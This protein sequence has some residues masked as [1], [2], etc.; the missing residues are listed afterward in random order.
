MKNIFLLAFTAPF[1]TN[2][3]TDNGNGNP[4]GKGAEVASRYTLE[5]PAN[6]DNPFDV[7]GILFY[8]VSEAFVAGNHPVGNTSDVISTVDRVATANL[9]FME[10]VNE[11][12]ELPDTAAIN[13][14]LIGDDWT[15]AEAINRSGLGLVA[16]N[17]VIRFSGELLLLEIDRKPYEIIY[18]YILDFEKNIQSNPQISAADQ[19]IALNYSSIL[20]YAYYFA[21]RQKQKP[22]DRNWD[23]SISCLIAAIDG[24]KTSVAK[25]VVSTVVVSLLKNK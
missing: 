7:S 18:R 3:T 8:D 20:R 16:R 11:N 9:D 1:F 4:L 19:R 5:Y 15:L 10:I 23:I 2:C 12:Y 22:R 21:N 25:G 13:T 14:C 24:S 6:P 17:E